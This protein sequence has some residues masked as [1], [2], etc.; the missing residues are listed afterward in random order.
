MVEEGAIVVAVTHGAVVAILGELVEDIE[1]V[2]EAVEDEALGKFW[3]QC[4]SIICSRTLQ[5]SQRSMVL[6]F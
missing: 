2:E 4:T 5:L 6:A 1:E 3:G